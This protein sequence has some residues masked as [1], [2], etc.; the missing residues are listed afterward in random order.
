VK[1]E[2]E[3]IDEYIENRNERARSFITHLDVSDLPNILELERESEVWEELGKKCLTCGSCS[4]VCP[5][6]YCFNIYDKVSL[7]GNSG[8][9]FRQWDTCLSKDYTLVAG[10]HVFRKNRAERVKNIR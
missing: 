6:C 5:T 8:E 3:E 7:D 9:R 10:G 2:K 1:A 4:M